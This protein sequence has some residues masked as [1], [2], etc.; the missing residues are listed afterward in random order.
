MSIY[1]LIEYSR[2]LTA[3]RYHAFQST[4]MLP[5]VDKPCEYLQRVEEDM[6]PYQTCYRAA[7][8]GRQE[9]LTYYFARVFTSFIIKLHY[10][11][12]HSS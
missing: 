3:R 12:L 6:Y 2:S 4:T 11:P 10:M 9:E 7:E 1:V 8:K 5:M